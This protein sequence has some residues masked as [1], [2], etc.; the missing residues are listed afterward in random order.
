MLKFFFYYSTLLRWLISLRSLERRCWCPSMAGL[1]DL[2]R[3]LVAW[4]RGRQAAQQRWS[5]GVCFDIFFMPFSSQIAVERSPHNYLSL[6][7]FYGIYQ[8][9]G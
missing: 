2:G 3:G 6:S 5:H 7:F 4:A 8:L 9:M 1:A